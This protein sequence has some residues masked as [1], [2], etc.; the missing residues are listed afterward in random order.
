MRES[1][2]VQEVLRPLQFTPDRVSA[3]WAA[4]MPSS[5]RPMAWRSV[6]TLV[7]RK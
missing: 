2:S 6:V 1:W 7:F 3:A 4:G 5:R